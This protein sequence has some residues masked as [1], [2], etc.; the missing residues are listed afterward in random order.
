MSPTGGCG[1]GFGTL[2]TFSLGGNTRGLEITTVSSYMLSSRTTP[3]G[4]KT[5]SSE[6]TETDNLVD[7][8]LTG[9][10]G[11]TLGGGGGVNCGGLD[12]VN[13]GGIGGDVGRVY[14]ATGSSGIHSS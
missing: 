1:G 9:G 12:G 6:S 3:L 10:G 13:C 8:F 11:G 5:G 4:G 14:T 7:G 2:T